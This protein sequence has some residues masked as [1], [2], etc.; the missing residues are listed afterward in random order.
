VTRRGKLILVAGPSGAGKDSIIAGAAERLCGDDRFVFARRI[1]TRPRD[2]GGEDHIAISRAA[3]GVLRERGELMLSWEAHGLAYGLPMA[4]ANALDAGRS[5]VANVSRTVIDE[6]RLRFPPVRVAFVTASPAILVDRLALRRRESPPEI[7]L[8]LGRTV[9]ALPADAHVIENDGPLH[10]AVD[11]FVAL[12][13][14]TV[15]RAAVPVSG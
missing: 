4:L 7:L 10:R 11:A 3:F 6:A 15:G 12:L 1:V 5:V 9:A 8:R 2:P 13:R 14:Q